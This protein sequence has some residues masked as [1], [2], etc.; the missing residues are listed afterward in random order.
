[1][2]APVKSVE[3][4]AEIIGEKAAAFLPVFMA[5]V[6]NMTAEDLVA[7]GLTEKQAA[8]VVKATAVGRAIVADNSYKSLAI[9]GP[10]SAKIYCLSM[11]QEL[12]KHSTQEEFWVITLSTKNTVIRTHQITK[13]TLRNSLVHPREVFR[14]AIVDSANCILVVHNH[15]SGDP[16]PSTQDIDV[17]DRLEQAGSLIGI[18]VLDHIVIGSNGATSIQ[19]FRNG[20]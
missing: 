15:P 20:R 11:F 3:V 18:P 19:Q 5:D 7:Y 6:L 14:P 10:D 16:T 1:V 13:G 17:T 2:G 12:A 4:F 9:T 8:K